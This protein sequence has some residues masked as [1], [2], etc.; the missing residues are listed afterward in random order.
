MT[1]KKA[2]NTKYRNDQLDKRIART[3]HEAP[4]L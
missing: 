4:W 2:L 3:Y 1:L